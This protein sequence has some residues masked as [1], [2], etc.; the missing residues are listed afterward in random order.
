M[1]QREG[2]D[3]RD[4]FGRCQEWQDR[5]LAEGE[6]E[7]HCSHISKGIASLTQLGDLPKVVA[8]TNK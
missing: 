6:E 8:V 2:L 1:G 7:R 5:H 4:R 3:T